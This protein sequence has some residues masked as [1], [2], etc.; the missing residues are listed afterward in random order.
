MVLGLSGWVPV[1]HGWLKKNIIS[2]YGYQRYLALQ[3]RNIELELNNSI[4]WSGVPFFSSTHLPMTSRHNYGSGA[5][6]FGTGDLWM[7]ET[8]SQA[9]K[10]FSLTNKHVWSILP[11]WH[12][13]WW[14]VLAMRLSVGW[15]SQWGAVHNSITQVGSTILHHCVWLST[16]YIGWNYWN[17][18]PRS[19][20]RWIYLVKRWGGGAKDD[21]ILREL[22]LRGGWG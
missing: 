14:K 10:L 19:G 17:D 2:W 8:H 22:G 20:S 1:I 7:T 5:Q 16:S 18:T 11:T 13:E 15:D 21:V 12:S 3:L 9:R 4:A 6:W